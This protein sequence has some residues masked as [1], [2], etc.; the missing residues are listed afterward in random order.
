MKKLLFTFIALT[1]ISLSAQ[2]RTNTTLAV[3][4][5]KSEKLIKADGWT[6]DDT[7]GEWK[8]GNNE[9]IS[10]IR[11]PGRRQNFKYMQM[12]KVSYGGE[13]LYVF[14]YLYK[15]G[16]FKYKAIKKGWVA[17]DKLQLIVL[18][19]NEFNSFASKISS[20][21]GGDMEVENFMLASK[22]NGDVW[23]SKIGDSKEVY[24]KITAGIT[25]GGY[26]SRGIVV[27]RQ[28]VDGNDVVRFNFSTYSKLDTAYFEVPAIEFMK[29][30]DL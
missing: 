24:G 27:N 10:Y 6:Q 1:T 14:Q 28:I 26:L 20:P 23:S 11:I 3:S 18:T 13:E 29:L 15:S 22:S 7:T 17:Y 19:Q 9:L 25:K 30:M 5:S 8:K 21:S 2:S 16:H 12:E 4:V